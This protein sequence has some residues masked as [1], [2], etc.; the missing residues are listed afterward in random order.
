M[1]E[2]VGPETDTF[3]ERRRLFL[4]KLG[5]VLDDVVK[6]LDLKA[7]RGIRPSQRKGAVTCRPPDL[8]K[9]RS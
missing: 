9:P 3:C 1:K 7:E 8:K 5:A 2:V 4:Q 6:I